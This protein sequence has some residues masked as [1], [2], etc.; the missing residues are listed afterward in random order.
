MILLSVC[1]PTYKR[2]DN[3][4]RCIQSVIDQ[5]ERYDLSDSVLIYVVDDASPDDTKAVMDEYRH[6]GY[7]DGISRQENLGMNQN[8]KVMLQEAAQLSRFQLI[9]TDDDKLQE[10]CLPDIVRYLKQFDE[11]NT[12][13]AVWTP[14]YSYTED[15]ELHAVLLNPFDHDVVIRPSAKSAAKYLVNGFVLSGLIVRAD[16]IDFTFWDSYKDNGYFPAIFFADYLLRSEVRYWN[17]NIAYHTVLNECHWERWGRND[18]MISLRLFSDFIKAFEIV[19]H[20]IPRLH[21]RII[22]RLYSLFGLWFVINGTLKKNA[23]RTFSYETAE[24]VKEMRSRGYLN[25]DI[26]NQSLV[27]LISLMILFWDILKFS[28]FLVLNTLTF[29]ENKTLGKRMVS[30]QKEVIYGLQKLKLIRAILL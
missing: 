23:L 19:A 29:F 3:L 6:L 7:F 22:Y 15:G 28:G 5:I 26:W 30:N 10:G 25:F 2:Q 1:I 14:R 21:S 27:F 9:I 12:P 11:E 8:I 18:I 16:M 20:R 13:V 24:V 4:R 17:K